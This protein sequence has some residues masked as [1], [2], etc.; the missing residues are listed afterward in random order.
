MAVAEILRRSVVSSEQPVEIIDAKELGLRLKLPKTW[1]EE[2][3]RSRTA[4]VI[5]HLRFGKYI[6]FRWNSPELNA[7]LARRAAGGIKE[8]R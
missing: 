2:G 3:T 1:I 8:V 4:D 7:W 6:R 5:P